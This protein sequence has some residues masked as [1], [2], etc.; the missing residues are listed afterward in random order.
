MR[1]LAV[2]L[3]LASPLAAQ[4]LD[5]SD[6]QTKSC[7]AKAGDLAAKNMCIGESSGACMETP[8]GGTT[9]GMGGCLD[10]ELQFWDALLNTNYQASM[11]DA[12]ALDAE[13]K[14]FNPNLPSQETALRDMQRAWIPFRDAACDYERSKWGGGTGGS[15]ATL[16]C[17]MELTGQQALRLEPDTR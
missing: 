8:N 12:K 2:L 1:A 14:T 3:C 7:L 9:V 11:T 15:P 13:N 17:L 6:T 4:D 10:G 16:A 5:Y